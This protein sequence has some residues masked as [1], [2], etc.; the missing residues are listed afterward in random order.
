MYAKVKRWY[1]NGWW[2]AENVHQAV[3]VGSITA[4]E[5]D[6]ILHGEPEPDGSGEDEGNEHKG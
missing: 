5:E 2:T 1:K 6:W 4:D 3:L